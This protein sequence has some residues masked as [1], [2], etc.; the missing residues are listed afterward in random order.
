MR[1]YRDKKRMDGWDYISYV[2][3]KYLHA[4]HIKGMDSR[5]YMETVVAHLQQVDFDK[6]DN[7]YAWYP[8]PSIIYMF[9][10]AGAGTIRPLIDICHGKDIIVGR[11]RVGR[12]GSVFD[13]EFVIL[14]HFREGN[15]INA[16]KIYHYTD[17]EG[18]CAGG[19]GKFLLTP[20]SER[21]GL[22]I[23]KHGCTSISQSVG[24]SPVTDTLVIEDGDFIKLFENKEETDMTSY[25]PTFQ[26]TICQ[27]QLPRRPSEELTYGVPAGKLQCSNPYA[28]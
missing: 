28:V 24:W 12:Q 2:Y 21:N 6:K 3:D 25:E 11:E 22:F 13:Q 23:R 17:S 1:A 5:M 14:D 10:G 16:F 27:A 19:N 18:W 26:F 7:S 20:L 4:F 15:C 8:Y 9:K